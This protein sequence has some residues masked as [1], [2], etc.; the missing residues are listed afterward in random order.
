[1]TLL[2][3]LNHIHVKDVL[4]IQV[5]HKFIDIELE[6]SRYIFISKWLL[7]QKNEHWLV[8]CCLGPVF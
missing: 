4:I 7:K 1:M 2:I 6:T 3:I 8:I 5:K